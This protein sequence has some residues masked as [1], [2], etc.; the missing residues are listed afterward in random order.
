MLNTQINAHGHACN[1]CMGL[2]MCVCVLWDV[3]DPKRLP[4]Q[5]GSDAHSSLVIHEQPLVA[6]HQTALN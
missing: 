6:T 1:V 3:Q 5:R 2:Y 4:V